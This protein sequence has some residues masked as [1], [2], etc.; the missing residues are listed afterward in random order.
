MSKLQEDIFIA[1]ESGIYEIEGVFELPT[2]INIYT[3]DDEEFQ[4]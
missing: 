2:V 3:Y 1:T 4:K